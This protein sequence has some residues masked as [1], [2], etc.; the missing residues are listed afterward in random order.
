M[1][2][3]MREREAGLISAVSRITLRRDRARVQRAGIKRENSGMPADVKLAHFPS[4][5]ATLEIPFELMFRAD[6][7]VLQHR[8][9]PRVLHKPTKR[10]VEAPVAKRGT[11]LSD[12]SPRKR[13]PFR[14]PHR[15]SHHIHNEK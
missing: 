3:V 14:D 4:R 9:P 6:R 1:P 12:F 13:R 10:P 15:S 8:L 7:I 5:E 11:K 2:S